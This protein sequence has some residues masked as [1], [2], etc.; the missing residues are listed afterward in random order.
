MGLTVAVETEDGSILEHAED[1]T[2]ILH[3]LL[4][5]PDDEKYA[6]LGHIDWYGDTTFNYLQ[7]TSFLREWRTLANKAQGEERV[8][9]ER[10]E[11]M[12]ERL[13]EMRHLYL[14]FCGD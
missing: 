3:R 4:P 14:T 8:L 10:I 7:V 2:N 1:P 11:Q 6:M 13:L 12:A 5:G 9:V